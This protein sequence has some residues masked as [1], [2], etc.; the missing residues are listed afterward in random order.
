MAFDFDAAVTVPLRM[1]PG[2]RRLSPGTPQ[3]IPLAPGSRHQR[4]KL[5]VLGAFAADALCTVDGFDARPALHALCTEA[6][7][8]QAVAW[9]WDGMRAEALRLGTAVD[10]HGTVEQTETGVFGLG[11]EVARCLQGLPPPWRLAAL[12]GLAFAEDVALVEATA[13]TLPWM[14][15]CLPSHW[16]PREKVGRS[17]ANVHA[18][19]ADNE[20]LLQASDALVAV[21]TGPQR[22]ERF[23]WNVTAHPRLHAHPDRVDAD[24]WRHTAVEHAWWR[25]EHQSFV[26]F[27]GPDGAPAA[28]FLI[29]VDVQPLA[30]ALATPGRARRLHDALAGAS[31]AVIGY[32]HLASVREPLLRWLA[33]RAARDD[34][35][36][37]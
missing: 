23:V 19:V 18:P 1:Q 25:T 14:T 26:P 13:G 21:A 33:D 30:Q 9:R 3:F 32:R 28:L 37:V 36:P 8:Q 2:L 4:E 15:V 27:H 17:L 10:I 12:F 5:A 11:D 6:Q 16:S 31:P 22:W 35:D 34:G 24:A 29:R 7:R 20:R